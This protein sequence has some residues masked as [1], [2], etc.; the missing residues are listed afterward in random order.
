[1]PSLILPQRLWLLL[2]ALAVPRLAQPADAAPSKPPA[3]AAAPVPAPEGQANAPAAP[4]P[5]VALKLPLLDDRFASVPVA[6][7][8]EEVVTLRELG[9]VLATSHQERKQAKAAAVGSGTEFRDILERMIDMRLIVR[10]AREMGLDQL[11]EVAR[12]IEQYK[13][14]QLRTVLKRHVVADAKA[15]AEKTEAVYKDLVR[16]YR[17]LSLFLDKK[18]D[19]EKL[20]ALLADG[21]KLEDVAKQLIADK[22]AKGDGVPHD[23]L[24]SQLNPPV[25]IALESTKVGQ[26]TAPVP[27]QKGFVVARLDAINYP[28]RADKR[29]EAADA[30]QVA[31][32]RETWAKFFY[33]LCDAYLKRDDKLVKAVD[34]QAPKPGFQALKKDRRVLARIKGDKP[35]TVGDVADAT[36][37]AFFH[38]I[39][40]AIE[41]KRINEQKWKSL[42]KL[43]YE[44]LLNAE[45]A[46]RKIA[47][48]EEY[49][50]EVEEY[51]RSLLFGA[52]VQRA[53]V[54][55]MKIE[56]A[57]VGKY[58]E[59]HKADFT[60]P[61]FFKLD[62]IVFPD[63][64]RA[65]AALEKLKAGTDLRW[66][67]ANADGQIQGE[68]RALQLDGNTYTTSSLPPAL[69][70][71]LANA[72]VGDFRLASLANQ[73]YAVAVLDVTPSQAQP[74]EEVKADILKK[75]M[76]EHMTASV[77]DWGAKLRKVHATQIFVTHIEG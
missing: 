15:D 46:R 20:P 54:P 36:E 8:G 14:N 55:D 64:K 66:L 27:V 67:R 34:F 17:V 18:E 31:A 53:V 6:V 45:A 56:E 22:K 10:E 62:A 12:G 13:D 30:A 49:R 28:E 43:I 32:E 33:K 7:L 37:V 35:I 39:K 25:R 52:F 38:G 2:A 69:A 48:T 21:K 75:L 44:R 60:Y 11:P 71:S 16:E 57:E 61:G 74:I 50:R 77:K 68:D 58:Y 9:D 41:E 23:V 3:A 19:A 26:L 40:E 1:M 47:E 24:A 76:D 4:S 5:T 65:Q 63:A 29:A 51:A 72:S 73:Y 42:D 59:S 70:Q